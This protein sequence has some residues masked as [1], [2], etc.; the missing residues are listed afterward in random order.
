MYLTDVG[1]CAPGRVAGTQKHTVSARGMMH[2]YC[3]S[4]SHLVSA[5]M[6]KGS[7]LLYVGS[8]R[9]PAQPRYLGCDPVGM[10]FVLAR[11]LAPNLGGAGLYDT[12]RSS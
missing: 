6:T 2:D 3:W 12:P 9:G 8:Q 1:T 11:Y 5:G 10:V 7:F 4:W